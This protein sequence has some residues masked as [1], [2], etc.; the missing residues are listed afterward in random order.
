MKANELVK[1][2]L[3]FEVL[4]KQIETENKNGHFKTSIAPNKWVSPEDKQKLLSD[5]FKLSE[6]TTFLG[7]Q[8]LIIEW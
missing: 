2:G 3:D 4:Y 6:V 8:M 5:G 7:E 1:T